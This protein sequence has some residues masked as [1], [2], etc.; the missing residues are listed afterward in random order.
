MLLSHISVIKYYWLLSLPEMSGGHTKSSCNV[1]VSSWDISRLV[2]QSARQVLSV[3][4]R[5][6]PRTKAGLFPWRTTPALLLWL[7]RACDQPSPRDEGHCDVTWLSQL[8]LPWLHSALRSWL[9]TSELDWSIHWRGHALIQIHTII[10]LKNIF[11]RL[12]RHQV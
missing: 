2:H 11:W 4:G 12:L 9:F 1:Y 8:A 3:L 6:Q 10:L 5:Y 7:W